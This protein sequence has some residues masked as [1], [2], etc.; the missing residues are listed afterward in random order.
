MTAWELSGSEGYTVPGNLLAQLHIQW[1]FSWTDATMR[2]FSYSCIR[3]LIVGIDVSFMALMHEC[4]EGANFVTFCGS[5]VNW[6][7]FHGSVV[8][9]S[10]QVANIIYCKYPWAKSAEVRANITSECGVPE[11]SDAAP[12]IHDVV[13]VDGGDVLLVL[14]TAWSRTQDTSE[15]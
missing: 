10:L 9:Q 4:E 8:P 3:G 6:I 13:W 14:E 7:A 1:N 15:T 5:W 12:A 2:S 11:P